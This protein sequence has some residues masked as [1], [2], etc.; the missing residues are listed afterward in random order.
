MQNS[1]GDEQGSLI[2]Q[3]IVPWLMVL[4]GAIFYSYESLLR[5]SPSVMNAELMHH[6]HISAS[7]FAHLVAYYY[8]I[9][10]PMQLFV[11]ILMDKYGPKKLLTMAALACALGTYLFVVSEQIIIA[12]VG[13]FMVGL[14]SSFAFVGVLKLATIWLPPERF[15]VVSGSTMAIGMVGC[16][17]GD[18]GLTAMVDVFGWQNAS[19]KAAIF[20]LILSLSIMFFMRE[21]KKPEHEQFMDDVP[22]KSL[23][24]KVVLLNCFN[25]IQ[26]RQIWINGIIGCLMWLPISIFAETWGVFYLEN[27]HQL[28]RSVAGDACSMVFLGWAVGGPLVGLFS[29]AL[30]QRRLPITLGAALAAIMISIVLYVPNL[31]VGWLFPILFLFGFF[32]SVQV[33]VFA[34]SRELSPI[35]STGTALA[36][37]NMFVMFAGVI[38]PMSGYLLDWM[39]K[40]PEIIDGSVHYS[41][42]AYE[43]ALSVLPL[44]LLITVVLSLFLK[45]TFSS[46]TKLHGHH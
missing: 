18:I 24:F 17:M 3:S 2:K 40:T 35:A 37:T 45:E 28:S 6:Y 25:L 26:N 38:Q 42:T 16:L 12:E 33:I 4:L 10:A 36:L 46:D 41:Q 5:Q 21:P 8:Y 1:D 39:T 14:G 13:R 7:S 22:N 44:G 32:N 23:S 34:V 27:V 19:F 11:G 9:Y 31:A 30:R 15:A 29:D 20:G 43:V